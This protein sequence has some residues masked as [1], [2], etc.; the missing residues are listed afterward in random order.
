MPD[1]VRAVVVDPSHPEG[2]AVEPVKLAGHEP[3]RAGLLQF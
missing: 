1:T 2:L 3:R